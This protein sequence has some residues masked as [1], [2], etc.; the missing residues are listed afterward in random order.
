VSSITVFSTGGNFTIKGSEREIK[1]IASE[2]SS[3]FR[4]YGGAWISNGEWTA[5][6]PATSSVNIDLGPSDLAGIDVISVATVTRR[7][8]AV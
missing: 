8:C 1:Q 7:R 2:L 5:W 4:L 3:G 6:V